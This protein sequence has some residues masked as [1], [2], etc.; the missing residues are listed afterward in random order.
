[1]ILAQGLHFVTSCLAQRKKKKQGFV[2]VISVALV[3]N[4]KLINEFKW[5]IIGILGQWAEFYCCRWLFLLLY[6]VKPKGLFLGYVK[7]VLAFAYYDMLTYVIFPQWF[8]QA[9]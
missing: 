6:L 2:L 7:I 4:K 8:A 5:V 3:D 1:M 9:I